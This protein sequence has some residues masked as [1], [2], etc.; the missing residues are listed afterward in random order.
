MTSQKTE[1]VN[2]ELAAEVIVGAADPFARFVEVAKECGIPVSTVSSIVRRM[3]RDAHP[4]LHELKSIKTSQLQELID[5][6]AMMAL[7]YM[8]E[9][10][11]EEAN[12]RDLGI[13]LGILLE[14]RQ[15]LRGEPTVI[16]SHA[17]RKHLNEIVPV[18]MEEAKRRGYT[19]DVTPEE[20]TRVIPPTVPTRESVNKTAQRARP[21]E[22]DR[23]L[24]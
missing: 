6:K 22:P 1:V 8:D 10:A 19:I 13:T 16:M 23:A 15:L 9:T 2:P 20:E 24:E 5:K 14:K 12:L 18:F 11:F 3:R 4:A 17:E 7:H 21:K